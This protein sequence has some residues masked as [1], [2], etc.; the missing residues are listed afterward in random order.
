[1]YSC[2]LRISC[3]WS[4]CTTGEWPEFYVK[5][6]FCSVSLL[7]CRSLCPVWFVNEH[8]TEERIFANKLD[9]D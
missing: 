9:Q 5:N 7:W 2:I 3:I 6:M 4:V 8:D 1:M